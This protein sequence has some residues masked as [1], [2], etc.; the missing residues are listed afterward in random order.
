MSASPEPKT[1]E[2]VVRIT[3]R[4][5]S[6]GALW[7]AIPTALLGIAV[8]SFFYGLDG[9]LG[10]LVGG[11]VVGASSLATLWAMRRTAALDVHLVMAAAL[12][13]FV[14]KML[15]LLGV[16][17]LLRDV[18]GL[19]P[20]AL[21]FTMIA[22]IVATAAAEAIASRRTRLPNVIPAAQQP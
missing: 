3:A 10:A 1:H 5:M 11:L 19:H 15:I 2:D 4:A 13:G 7:A 17:M 14:V 9:A 8:S 6:R 18:P 12:G 22:M 20:R 21:A 16:M